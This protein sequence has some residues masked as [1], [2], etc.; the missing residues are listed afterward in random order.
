[1]IPNIII[2]VQRQ[3]RYNTN[4]ITKDRDGEPERG[5]NGSQ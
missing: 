5:V 4:K 2:G 1:M 3:L